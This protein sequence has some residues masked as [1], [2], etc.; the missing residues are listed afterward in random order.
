M[1]IWLKK[2]CLESS[3]E[4]HQLEAQTAPTYLSSADISSGF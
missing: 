4:L 2:R 3:E 1:R